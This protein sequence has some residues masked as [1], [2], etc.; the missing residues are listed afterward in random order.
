[1][2]SS[3]GL[4]LVSDHQRLVAQGQQIVLHS[5]NAQRAHLSPDGRSAGVELGRIGEVKALVADKLGPHLRSSSTGSY[6]VPEHGGVP[7]KLC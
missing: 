6:P 3:S 4:G 5:R 7:S 1:M 2:G